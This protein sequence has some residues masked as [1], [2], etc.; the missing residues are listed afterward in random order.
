MIWK[1]LVDN[2]SNE[3]RYYKGWGWNTT[4][5]AS[6]MQVMRIKPTPKA[7]QAP[8][9]NPSHLDPPVQLQSI[10]VPPCIGRDALAH[11]VAAP[12][13]CDRYISMQWL[14]PPPICQTSSW[15]TVQLGKERSK[16]HNKLFKWRI[17]YY[18]Y[19]LFSRI[20]VRGN[21]QSWLA[22]KPQVP[23]VHRVATAIV[24]LY[25]IYNGAW[26]T[27]PTFLDSLCMMTNHYL[28]TI[29]WVNLLLDG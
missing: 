5:K 11:A 17:T 27:Q 25:G 23:N 18:C 16:F 20:L 3:F 22:V 1:S 10:T 29:Y 7:S 13:P 28:E 14:M 24:T 26:H 2:I 19:V 9:H 6:K 12:A 15:D 21:Y 8:P 4:P